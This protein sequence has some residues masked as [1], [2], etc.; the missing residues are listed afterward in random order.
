MA[1]IAALAEAYRCIPRPRNAW[2]RL[3]ERLDDEDVE[4][5]EKLMRDPDVSTADIR[6]IIVA[7]GLTLGRDTLYETRRDYLEGGR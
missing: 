7:A 5:L 4:A 3:L 1:H 6:R 2:D